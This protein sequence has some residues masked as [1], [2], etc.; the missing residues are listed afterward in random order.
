[1][2][3]LLPRTGLTTKPQG[4]QVGKGHLKG[5]RGGRGRGNTCVTY[6]ADVQAPNNSSVCEM[7][8]YKFCTKY[9]CLNFSMGTYHNFIV[10]VQELG[11]TEGYG[12]MLHD[13]HTL[14][15]AASY[16]TN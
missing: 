8:I 5:Q 2:E 1:M 9:Y 11:A 7:S 16:S 15:F 6:I 10:P 14:H 12:L 13:G 3:G 4:L